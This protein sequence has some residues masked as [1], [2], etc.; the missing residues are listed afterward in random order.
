[1]EIILPIGFLFAQK[2]KTIHAHPSFNPDLIKLK[3]CFIFTKQP[4]VR[5]KQPFIKI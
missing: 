5:T 2:P 1:M 3:G 4:L